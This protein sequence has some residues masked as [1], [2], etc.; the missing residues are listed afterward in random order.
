[1]GLAARG[2]EEEGQWDSHWA[3]KYEKGQRGTAVG[4]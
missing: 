2:W 4:F 3:K 1:M